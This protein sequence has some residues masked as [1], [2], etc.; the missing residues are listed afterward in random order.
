MLYS[1]VVGEGK[2][3]VFLHGFSEDLTL[4]DELADS[5]KEYHKIITIDLPGFGKS[6]AT[7]GGFS[8]DDIAELVN[9][10]ILND[11]GINNYIVFGHSLG[12]YVTLAI[13]DLFPDNV[14]GVGLINSTSYADSPEKKENRL[15]TVDFINKHGAS[16][17]LKSFVPELFTPQNQKLL[18]GKVEK[19]LI[20]GQDLPE[21]V[22]TS[23]MLAMRD[24]PDRSHLLS[25]IENFLFIGG[26]EDS[27]FTIEQ[28]TTQIESL[29]DS[30]YGQILKKIAHMSMF[31]GKTELLSEILR[32]A[33]ND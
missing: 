23:Y 10:H 26:E 16:F 9:S 4:W 20:M 2:A 8:L 24:R 32:F 19:V 6:P 11:L 17:F 5:L 7:G 25:E 1:N 27:H 12:G 3:L 28:M 33:K 22:L 31:E 13:A 14:K 21:S 18:A 29:K 15:K 30:S